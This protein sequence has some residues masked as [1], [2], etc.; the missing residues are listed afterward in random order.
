MVSKTYL[1]NIF[2]HLNKLNTNMQGRNEILL[3]TTDKLYRFLPIHWKLTL[4]Q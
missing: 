2:G 1:T 3:T 4:G